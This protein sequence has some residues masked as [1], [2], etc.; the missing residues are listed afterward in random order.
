MPR[1]YPLYPSVSATL[2]EARSMTFRGNTFGQV[3]AYHLPS[4]EEYEMADNFDTSKALAEA[5]EERR[6]IGLDGE[7]PNP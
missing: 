7:T 6:R 3:D 4:K 2:R 1:S 5:F